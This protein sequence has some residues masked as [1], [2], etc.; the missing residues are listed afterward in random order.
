MVNIAVLRPHGQ[1]EIIYAPDAPIPV[2]V[3][4]QDE[5]PL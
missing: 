3:D 1:G 4:L 5:L 2:G